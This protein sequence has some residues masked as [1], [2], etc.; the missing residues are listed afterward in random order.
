MVKS[1]PFSHT[2]KH[3][4]LFLA[5]ALMASIQAA[6]SNTGTN[7]SFN[8]IMPD[9][10][11]AIGY[12]NAIT[13]DAHGFM[14]FGGASGLAR[15]DGYQLKIY[16]YQERNAGSLSHTYINSLLVDSAGTLWVGTRE[17][18]NQYNPGTDN[19]TSFRQPNQSTS[20]SNADDIRSMYED[21]HGQFWLGTRGGMYAFDRKNQAYHRYQISSTSSDLLADNIVWSITED[22]QGSLWVGNHSTGISRFD[23]AANTFQHFINQ[24]I[25][26]NGQAQNDVRRLYVDSLNRVWAGTYGGGAFVFN[27]NL[28]RFEHFTHDE[29]AREKSRIVWDFVEDRGGNIW[30]GDGDAVTYVDAISDTRSRFSYNAK[31]PHSPGNY[32]VNKLFVDNAGNVWAG[33]F[34]SGVDIVDKQAGVFRNYT[35]DPDNENSVSDGGV[36]SSFEDSRGNL[37]IGAGYGLNYFDRAANTIKQTLYDEKNRTGIS[38]NTVLSV[39]ED[40]QQTL[41]L[42]IW[43]GGLNRRN[44]GSDTFSHY[45]PEE[46]NPNSLLGK[47]PWALLIDQKKRL[48]IATDAGVNRYQP[49]TDS[50][51]RYLPRQDQMD[52][53]V[54]LY[55][56]ALL[57]DSRG[58]LWVGSIRG[59]YHLN[60]DTHGFTRYRHQQEQATSISDDYVISLFE[61]SKNR[62]WVG[63]HGGGLN[64]FD[65]EAGTFTRY[66]S[67]NGLPDDVVTGIIEDY[68]GYLWLSTQQG[69]SQFNPTTES[70]RN[71]NKHHG[72]ADNLFNRNT[73]LITSD[74]EVFFGNS[75]G[76]V[77]FNPNHLT[78]NYH[79]PP[80]A[81]TDF[82]LF[83]QSVYPG[84]ENSPLTNTIEQTKSL[85]VRHHQSM[86]SFTFSALDY[87]APDRNQYSY[88]LEGFDNSWINSGTN[89]FATY[90]NLDSGSYTLHVKAANNDGIWSTQATTIEIEVLP[91]NW[92]TWWA[93]VLYAGLL[94]ALIYGVI[95]VLVSRQAY[96]KEHQLTKR[97]LD[98]DILKDEFLANTSHELRTPLNGMIGLSEGLLASAE[99]KLDADTQQKLSMIS[100]SGKRLSNLINEILDYSKLA[101]SQQPLHFQSVDLFMLTEMVFSLL[102]P[103]AEAKPLRLINALSP[104]M[105]RVNAD[106][107]RLQQILINLVGNA[108]KYTSEGFVTVSAEIQSS[109]LKISVEDS[110]VGIDQDKLESIFFPFQQIAP[111]DDIQIEGTGLGL[112]VCKKLVELHGGTIIVRS[113]PNSGSEFIFDVPIYTDEA[114]KNTE[115]APPTS[116]TRNTQRARQTKA[117][118]LPHQASIVANELRTVKLPQYPKNPCDY[119]ILIVD[120]D[121]VNCT[122]LSG[123]LSLQ[124]YRVIEAHSGETAL[125]ILSEQHIDLVVLDAIMPGMNGYTTCEKIRATHPIDTLAVIFLTANTRDKDMASGYHSGGSDFI[126]KPASHTELLHK[127]A[128][129]LR[130]TKAVGAKHLDAV[131][132]LHS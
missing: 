90:T 3:I 1:P 30:I 104:N 66:T 4:T 16:R 132:K 81:I 77:L 23:M 122:I 87:R 13:Q 106:E 38:G 83:N 50:F 119:T 68:K 6:A 109:R 70:F 29:Q 62:I 67:A 91:P 37:W 65:P 26:P 9:Q 58:N 61:D 43:S 113:V 82:R 89:R 69:L 112:T 55:T 101:D 123:I 28:D 42:G 73:P 96:K 25:D 27:R 60:P 48:W 102:G 5:M 15:Y 72:L 128:V 110:G 44:S 39:L 11:H 49:E 85:T 124:N 116:K 117:S 64:L 118:L 2:A 88:W 76:F 54:T 10:I 22:K 45:L 92:R 79:A 32:A 120:D 84:E 36:L 99:N 129:H 71:F 131:K 115:T 18:L 111:T 8:H 75:R 97:L 86:L 57:E 108:I 52:G 51:I 31:E 46:N 35:Y 14:W 56:R 19:F 47:E 105:P 107:D 53:D 130:L 17:G 114:P 34:P 40:E 121:K 98:L 21:S 74:G 127:V 33:Y 24:T 78:L 41:W 20:A 59:L 12:I 93:Y 126:C 80:V 125:S 94:G 100:L 95:T 63:T 7:V 103:L